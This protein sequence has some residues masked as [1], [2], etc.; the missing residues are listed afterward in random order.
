[1]SNKVGHHTAAELNEEV[2][3][4]RNV[5]NIEFCFTLQMVR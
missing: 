1:M 3:L 4:V 2:F 5:Q